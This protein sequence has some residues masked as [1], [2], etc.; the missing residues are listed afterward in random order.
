ME[1]D[2]VK[3]SDLYPD[4]YIKKS[5]I[6]EETQNI[7][8]KLINNSFNKKYNG[9]SGLKTLDIGGNVN[10]T[11]SL[12]GTKCFFLDPFIKK[13]NWYYK[14][15]DW[16]DLVDLKYKFNIIVAK[17]SLNYLTE[18]ELKIIP[19]VLKKGGTFIANT[20][21]H[22]REIDREFTNSK[23][24]VK[25]REK[26]IFKKGKIYHYLHVGDNVIEHSFF[27]YDIHKL[28]EIFEGENLSF[29]I[30]TPSSMIIKIKK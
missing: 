29:E 7:V 6:D 1:I 26:T 13:P 18:S 25:G 27:H 4:R 12:K 24:G 16:V 21:I 20:F 19:K 30:T 11:E 15:V 3:Y 22:P 5:K 8:L 9:V 17:N 10:G 2:W 23:T 28:I 14:Q